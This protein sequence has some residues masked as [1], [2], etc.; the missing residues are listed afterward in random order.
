MINTFTPHKMFTNGLTDISASQADML[1][2]KYNIYFTTH[3][4]SSHTE[5]DWDLPIDFM[6][7]KL[8]IKRSFDDQYAE[9]KNINFPFKSRISFFTDY[10]DNKDLVHKRLTEANEILRSNG[11][12]VTASSLKSASNVSKDDVLLYMKGL[13]RY[14]TGSLF[15]NLP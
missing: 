13:E 12:K 9:V 6:T 14:P 3:P 8:D 15:E 10:L 11:K 2:D 1:F 7:Y 4:I 5:W